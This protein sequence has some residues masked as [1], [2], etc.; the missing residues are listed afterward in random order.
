MPALLQLEDLSKA[1]RG[2]PAL[3]GLSLE[4]HAGEIVGFIG[5]N[6]AGKTTTIKIVAGLAFADGGRVFV[7][8]HRLEGHGAEAR[9][10]RAAL[11]LLP[12]RPYLYEKLTAREYVLFVAG[13]YGVERA[14]AD[15]HLAEMAA[16]FRMGDYVDRPVES[17]SHGMKQ[18]T[19]LCA[20]LVHRPPVF[21]CDE[22]LV[23]LD[24]HGA[25]E[26][27][28]LVLELKREGLAVLISS[29]TLGLVEEICDRV[30]ILHRGRL[31]AE[32]TVAEIRQ[33]ARGQG[34]LEEV[35]LE[36]T[37]EESATAGAGE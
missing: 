23:G 6:G 5:P 36:M 11:G 2:Q 15:A 10:A 28:A 34:P 21:V 30:A 31:I 19:A 33:R 25:R 17:M 9:A 4:V 24:P 27:K 18:K 22:P 3:V 13:L 29:H 8:G 37:E 14:A 16:R 35:F 1:Y 26:F 32:G 12:D 20:A 7:D